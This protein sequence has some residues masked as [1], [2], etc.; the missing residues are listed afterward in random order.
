MSY[1]PCFPGALGMRNLCVWS[2]SWARGGLDTADGFISVGTHGG[3]QGRPRG[4][5][6]GSWGAPH[7]FMEGVHPKEECVTCRKKV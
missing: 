5:V 1:C 4:D 6:G 3:L 2:V 7:V